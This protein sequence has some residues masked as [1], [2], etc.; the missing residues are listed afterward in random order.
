[1]LPDAILHAYL[2]LARACLARGD[3]RRALQVLEDLEDFSTARSLPRLGAHAL[4]ERVRIHAQRQRH[5]TAGALLDRLDSLAARFDEP[6]FAPFEPQF[7]LLLA[8]ARSRVAL[9]RGQAEAAAAQLA[10]AEGLATQ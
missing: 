3:E 9:A 2:C 4:A 8:G 7:R 10:I 6:D 1:G 5:E